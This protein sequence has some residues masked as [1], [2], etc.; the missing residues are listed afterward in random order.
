MHHID[1]IKKKIMS[2]EEE[3]EFGKIDFPV[4]YD[5]TSQQLLWPIWF[6]CLE[7]CPICQW[8]MGFITG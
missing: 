1:R 7:H 3:K 8:V 2:I 6:S 4:I 5:K